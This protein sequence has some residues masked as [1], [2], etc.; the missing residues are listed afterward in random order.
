MFWIETL[1]TVVVRVEVYNGI[2][3][4]GV[5]YSFGRKITNSG[6][7]VVRY[8]NAPNMYTK[9]TL[10]IPDMESFKKMLMKLFQML[11]QLILILLKVDQIL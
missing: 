10:F 8:E 3:L 11:Y 1:R 2:G 5:A 7:D 6:C 4:T 9:T